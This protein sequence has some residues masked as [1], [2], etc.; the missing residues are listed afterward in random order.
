MN[1]EQRQLIK[2]RALAERESKAKE[3]ESNI[4]KKQAYYE[5]ELAKENEKLAILKL[6]IEAFKGLK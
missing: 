2:E 4:T 6:E 1:K 3:L 5:A